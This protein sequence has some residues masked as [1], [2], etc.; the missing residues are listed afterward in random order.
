MF[1]PVFLL[2]SIHLM[3]S[4]IGTFFFYVFLLCFCRA[5]IWTAGVDSVLELHFMPQPLKDTWLS[6][7][8]S[9]GLVVT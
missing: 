3:K 1:L 4:V 6:L 9:W 2:L 7:N 5:V 8:V